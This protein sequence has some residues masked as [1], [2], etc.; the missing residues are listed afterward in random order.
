MS[1]ENELTHFESVT[2]KK[3]W[4]VSVLIVSFRIRYIIYKSPRKEEKSSTDSNL[5]VIWLPEG[6]LV[7]NVGL[8]VFTTSPDTVLKANDY[9]CLSDSSSHQCHFN[10]W[11]S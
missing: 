4:L 8:P 7:V 1:Q 11:F 9:G 6:K 3:N 5:L 2:F 10:L